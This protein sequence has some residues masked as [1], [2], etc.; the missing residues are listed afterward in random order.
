MRGKIL[1][2]LGLLI[3]AVPFGLAKTDVSVEVQPFNDVTVLILDSAEEYFLLYA[4]EGDSGPYGVINFSFESE[5][6]TVDVRII[7]ERRGEKVNDMTFEGVSAYST[8]S[9]D[10]YNETENFDALEDTQE[11]S[12]D[13]GN[14]SED[15]NGS[16]QDNSSADDL[17]EDVNLDAENDGTAQGVTGQVVSEDNEGTGSSKL[18]YY[19]MAAVVLAGIIGFFVAKR[20]GSA[21]TKAPKDSSLN[22][23]GVEVY[24]PRYEI[25]TIKPKSASPSTIEDA[26][27]KIKDLE[28][29]IR[30]VKQTEK[31]IEAQKR[32]EE[33]KRDLERLKGEGQ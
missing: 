2:L 30:T 16:T 24:N 33:A 11:S 20:L 28:E 21:S 29:E 6:S 7:E 3:L 31:L 19:L 10:V 26:E 18:F 15:L 23:R 12:T 32:F 25:A 9:L 14:Q 1:V 22:R 27:Q 17:Q 4:Y 13:D 5:K 8:I